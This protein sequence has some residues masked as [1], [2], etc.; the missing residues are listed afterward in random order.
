MIHPKNRQQLTYLLCIV[1]FCAAQVTVSNEGIL[2]QLGVRAA[3]ANPP[4]YEPQKEVARLERAQK[5]FRLWQMRKRNV[6]AEVEP[7]LRDPDSGIRHSTVRVLGR[8]KNAQAEQVLAQ[9]L[10]SLQK[11]DAPDIGIAKFTVQL[12]LGHIRSRELKG[13]KRLDAVARSA[14]FSWKEI[15]RL[16]QQVSSLKSWEV[17]N[18]PGKELIT[19]VV[20][21]L[22]EMGRQGENIKPFV[23]QLSLS[24]SQ[25]VALR[26]ASLSTGER[27]A[28]ILTYLVGLDVVEAGDEELERAF[29]IESS[30]QLLNSLAESLVYIRTNKDKRGDRGYVTVFRTVALTRNLRLLNMLKQIEEDQ[31]EDKIIRYYAM[32]SRVAM[33]EK[34]WF[35]P[36]P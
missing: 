28:F 27:P 21:V 34:Q 35:P 22:G 6:T 3:S 32:Q 15:V 12:A 26:A 4:S 29:F 33:E 11:Q 16:S 18:T 36:L 2:K 7:F 10:L 30:P 5:L 17:A 13:Q 8:L 14:G 1:L 19:E 23:T 9:L 31:S 25:Q 24:S 20:D